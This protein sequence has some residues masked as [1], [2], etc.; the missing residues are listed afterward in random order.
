MATR[1]DLPQI[2]SP[3]DV[4]YWFFRLNGC[5]TIRNFVVHPERRGSQLT[6][7]DLIAVRFPWRSEQNLIDHGLFEMADRSRLFL[8][9]V[10]SGGDCRLNGPWT[11][12]SIGNLTRV[13]EAIGCFDPDEVRRTT[14]ALYGVG[15]YRGDVIDALLVAVASH[16]SE[17]L[18]N[19]AP[20][21]VQLTWDEIFEFIF[22][23]FRL[24][25]AKK[26]HHPQWDP[27][28]RSLYTLAQHARNDFGS[29]R[30][31]VQGAF[32]V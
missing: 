5:L 16:R 6:D 29:F 2:G 23:R 24:F 17:E 31:A 13:L 20:G 12:R 22:S 21:A 19:I 1:A 9:E 28:G 18:V 11:D 14:E 10:K 15:R 26:A 27:Q 7:A 32:F 3:E 4:A 25:R 30:A 8:V